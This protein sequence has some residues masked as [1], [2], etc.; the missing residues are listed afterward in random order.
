M[1]RYLATAR[2]LMGLAAV[3]RGQAHHPQ[4][5]MV[6]ALAGAVE[7]AAI[8]IQTHP[9]DEPGRLPQPTTDALNEAADLL[10]GHDFRIPAVVLGY[11]TAPVTG[12]T[13][14]MRPL[15]TTSTQLAR[16]DA[17]L[18]ARRAAVVEHGHLNSRDEDVLHAAF[19]ALARMHR[20]HDRLAAI[21]AADNARPAN[22]GKAPADLN[23]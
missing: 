15:D 17:D 8:A 3:I 9:V 10:A 4:R 21:A 16:Q 20:A 12:D 5:S 1:S 22:R 13:P 2:R 19:T 14:R 18:R 11:A 23:R 7:D 6:E